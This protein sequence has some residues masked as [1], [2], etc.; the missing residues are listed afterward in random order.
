[1]SF[2]SVSFLFISISVFILFSCTSSKNISGNDPG[3]ISELRFLS[4]YR[5]PWGTQFKGATT[6]GLSGI[7][8]DSKRDL[9]Y[10]ICDDPSS[11]GPARYYTA[12]I[13]LGNSTIDSV[14]ILD[15]IP[16]LDHNGQ[17]FPNIT[18]D[19]HHS[20]DVEA[21]RYD[22]KRDE[23]IWSSEGQRYMVDSIAL[24]DP[25]IF[26]MNRDGHYKDSFE[27][28]ANMHIVKDKKG[29]RHNG[30]FE[31]ITFD[32]NYSHVFLSIEEPLWEDGPRA[33]GGD[34]TGWVR[35]LKF[36]RKLK[37]CMAQY[38]Y[39]IDAVPYPADPV[40]AY[41][42]NGISDILYLGD[43]KFIVMERAFSTGRIPS[44]V[45][46]YIAD[47]KNAED[48]TSYTL[49]NGPPKKPI[50]KKLLLDMNTLGRHIDNVEGV[51]FGPT[52]PNGHR[53]LLFVT[54]D[55]FFSHQKTQFFLFEVI[56]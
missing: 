19:R 43:D 33:A 16:L 55:N 22:A 46:L 5:L 23:L 48:I 1:M 2:K 44:D 27:L 40:G 17:Q 54:D 21:I 51:T 32:K 24:E 13:F 37:Q 36:N 38:A 31:G 8:Y 35:I 15:M 20:V 10:I 39:Q 18:K 25:A 47:A 3:Q 11:K 52:L 50:T 45:R 28:P 53:T 4:E 9:Y 14:S 30:V 6:G 34:T 41:K 7:D 56:P 12:K 49:E 29:P 26:I 42:V